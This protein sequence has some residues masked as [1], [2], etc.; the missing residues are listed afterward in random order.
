VSIHWLV[1]AIAVGIVATLIMD[2]LS[3]VS[4]RA[5]LNVPV[6]HRSIGRLARGWLRGRFIYRSPAEIE[7]FGDERLVGIIAHY[8]IG[9]AFSVVYFA[10]LQLLGFRAQVLPTFLYGVATSMASLL[11]L[12]PMV[13][14]GVACLGTRGG[15]MM[16]RSSLV[17]HAYYGIGLIFGD[18]LMTGLSR[19][20]G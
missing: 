13:G 18:Y 15:A 10:I 6:D 9:I 14:L 12:F 4:A 8:A 5:G 11:V 1:R 3:T 20:T 17:N 7:P 2:F 16:R 19:A